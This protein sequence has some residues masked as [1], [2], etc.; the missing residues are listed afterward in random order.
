MISS[1]AKTPIV[2]VAVSD[3]HAGS[4]IGLSPNR[5]NLDDGGYYTASESQKWMF[6]HWKDFI[7]KANDTAD[8]WRAPIVTVFNGDLIDGN[9]HGSAQLIGAGNKTTQLKMA[10]DLTRP[11]VDI[12]SK[13]YVVRGTPAHV[14]R[15]ASLEERYADDLTNCGRYS[16]H[17]ASWWHLPLNVH[18]TIFD[19]AH[20]GKLGKLPWTRANGA[21]NVAGQV[22]IE[23]A[24]TG[25]KPP[26]VIV[27][28]HL[29][30][31]A[32]TFHNFRSTRLIATPAFQLASAY[33]HRIHPGSV[34]HVGGIIFT[35]F[36]K[37]GRGPGK[38]NYEA[39]VI[40]HH[41]TRPAARKALD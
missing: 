40:V 19:F 23:Y 27:R 20:H 39:D 28:S 41:P 15:S 11:L 7:K 12:S 31:Y 33:I 17:V 4:T 37:G 24:E 34:A 13:V 32:D 14:G 30:Q 8:T 10:W 5:V 21:H 3:L 38:R 18:G 1:N 22:I 2:V 29:H 6:R 9:H 36:P 26:D 16:D 25:T 35:V